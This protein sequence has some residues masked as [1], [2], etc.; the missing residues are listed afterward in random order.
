MPLNDR[1]ENPGP[2]DVQPHEVQ[3]RVAHN[4]RLG[5]FSKFVI[6]VFNA[7]GYR[8]TVPVAVIDIAPSSITLDPANLPPFPSLNSEPSAWVRRCLLAKWGAELWKLN[9]EPEVRRSRQLLP[10]FTHYDSLTGLGLVVSSP[11]PFERL[12]AEGE[13][14]LAVKRPCLRTGS[15]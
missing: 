9:G 4:L 13:F 5:V 11:Q 1:G 14:V 12:H 15:P 7:Q 6:Q 8:A 10:R 2:I 3:V